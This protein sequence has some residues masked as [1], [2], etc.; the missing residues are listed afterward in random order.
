MALLGKTSRAAR[1]VSLGPFAAALAPLLYAALRAAAHGHLGSSEVTRAVLGDDPR[2]WHTPSMLLAKACTLVPLGPLS[3]RVATASALALALAARALYRSIDIL[4]RAQGV[5]HEALIQPL[6]LGVTLFTCGAP[7]LFLQGV[8]PEAYALQ[9]ALALLCL[10]RLAELEASWPSHDLRPLYAAAV[11]FG[12]CAANDLRSALV[13]LPAALPTLSRVLHA[14]NGEPLARALALAVFA[15][16]GSA[17]GLCFVHAEPGELAVGVSTVASATPAPLVIVRAFAQE[18]G[19]FALIVGFGAVAALQTPGVRRVAVLWTSAAVA[20]LLLYGLFAHSSEARAGLGFI[21]YSLPASAVLAAALPGALLAPDGRSRER[22]SR[23]QLGALLVLLAIGALRLHHSASETRTPTFTFL[24]SWSARARLRLPARAL[25]LLRDGNA[26]HMLSALEA[27]DA[28]R[29]DLR[30]LPLWLFDHEKQAW[31]LASRDPE[32]RALLRTY[33]LEGELSPAELETLAARRPVLLDLDAR[34]P[35]G[36]YESLQ[37]TELF[38]EV[39]GAGV[40]KTEERASAAAFHEDFAAL[41]EAVRAE[42]A[43]TAARDRLAELSWAA[44]LYFAGVG[45]RDSARAAIAD[46]REL[47]RTRSGWDALSA[48]LGGPSARGPIDVRGFLPDDG[49]GSAVE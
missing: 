6:A 4:L 9:M 7:A 30:V 48:L 21:A 37:L 2:A 34:T 35:P 33:L 13:L 44:A 1:A 3:L 32:L 19:L 24:D 39:T 27:E 28:T 11:A 43:D 20:P 17:I 23:G 18:L 31:E 47:A 15:G 29:P 22:V 46:G 5:A 38:Y 10:S 42:P 26:A 8:L 49:T 25:L 12:L 14:K 45:D 41:R 36:L 40:S 16:G